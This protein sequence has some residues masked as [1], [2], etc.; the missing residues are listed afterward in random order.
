V[1]DKLNGYV[2]YT[3]KL[4]TNIKCLPPNKRI[5]FVKQDY[6]QTNANINDNNFVIDSDKLFYQT[7]AKDLGI[8]HYKTNRRGIISM[9]CGTGK[10]Y[11]SYLIAQNIGKQIIF[12]SPL[13]QFAKQNL[14]RFVEY[15]YAN[16][17]LLVD[18][19]GERNINK[20]KK[21]IKSNESF[22]IS[23]T[24]DSIDVIQ[25]LIQYM[26]DPFFIIDEFHNILNAKL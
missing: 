10:T 4:S 13:R 9:P 12:I 18:S 7:K 11:T 16:N 23:L 1:L 26:V 8:V 24:Y 3:N 5:E 19:D 6:V 20:I 15:G 14:D 2:Y 17:Y 21:F 22:L 25:P